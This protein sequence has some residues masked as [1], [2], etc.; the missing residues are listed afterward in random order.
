MF[1]DSVEAAVRA[2]GGSIAD[3][4]DLE[5]TVQDVMDSKLREEQLMDVD[6]TLRDLRL[7]R[8]AFVATLRSMYHSRQVRALVE[9]K[10]SAA[11]GA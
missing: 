3:V 8:D 9:E 11:K 5:R 4:R 10:T 7:I 6:F 1:A 2:A